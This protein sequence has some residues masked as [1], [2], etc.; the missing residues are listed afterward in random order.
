MVLEKLFIKVIKVFIKTF[1]A[2]KKSLKIKNDASFYF[3]NFFSGGEGR[4]REGRGGFGGMCT[5]HGELKVFR[6]KYK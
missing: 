1:Q 5:R 2:S 3:K 6:F 4:R